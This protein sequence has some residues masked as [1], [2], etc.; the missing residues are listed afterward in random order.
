M[1]EPFRDVEHASIVPAQLGSDMLQARWR[2][3]PQIDNGV[4]DRATRAPDELGFSFG[5]G[6]PMHAAQ[7]S[8]AAIET[9][10][11]LGHLW[12]QTVGAELFGAKHSRKITPDVFLAIEVDEESASQFGFGEGQFSQF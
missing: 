9:D 6:L 7:G 5:R 4:E 11:A 1:R 3:G 12:V 8:L 2:V 10:A